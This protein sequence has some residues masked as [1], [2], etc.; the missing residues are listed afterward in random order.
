LGNRVGPGRV[1]A[2]ASDLLKW[3]RALY[4]EDLIKK[5]TLA[6]AFTPAKLKRGTTYPYG[7]GWMLAKHPQLGTKIFHTGDN[8]GYKTIIIRYTDA[9]KTLIVLCNNGHPK[10][11]W[12]VQEIE[13]SM[14]PVDSL[15]L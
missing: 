1:S 3:D 6:D 11:D 10:F 2:T 7:F 4:G 13:R 8:P 12:L 15:P 5:A 14:S 9:R